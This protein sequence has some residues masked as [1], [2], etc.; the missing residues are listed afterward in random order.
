MACTLSDGLAAIFGAIDVLSTRRAEKE[1]LRSQA[2]VSVASQL[3]QVTDGS[4]AIFEK[5]AHAAITYVGP[6][7]SVA[8]LQSHWKAVGRPDLPRRAEKVAKGS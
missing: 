5:L 8:Q 3:A 1:Y 2:V 7:A 6:K 4:L